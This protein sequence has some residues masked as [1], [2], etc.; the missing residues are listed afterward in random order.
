[1]GRIGDEA[2]ADARADHDLLAVQGLYSC[3]TCWSGDE[4]CPAC[5]GTGLVPVRS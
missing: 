2:E 3:P 5:D 4:S 1:M